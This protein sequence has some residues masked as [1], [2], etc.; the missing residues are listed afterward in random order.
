[1][2]FSIGDCLSDILIGDNTCRARN[3]LVGHDMVL[4]LLVGMAEHEPQAGSSPPP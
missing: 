2:F 1:M 3:G 4:A